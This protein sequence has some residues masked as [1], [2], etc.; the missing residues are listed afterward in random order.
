MSKIKL[1]ILLATIGT[2]SVRSTAIAQTKPAAKPATDAYRNAQWKPEK[3]K[4]YFSHA[5]IYEYT[6]KRDE[7]KG[8]IWI[9]IDPVTGTMCFQRESSFG[10]T[11]DMNELILALPNGKMIA[12]GTTESGKKIQ[13][14]FQNSSVKPEPDE[15]KDQQQTFREQ[16]KPTGNKRPEFGWESQE[17]VLSYLK[18]NESTKLWVAEVPFKVYPL[19]AFDEWEGDAQLPVSFS[20]IYLLGPNQLVTESDDQYGSLKLLSYEPNPLF[21]DLNQYAKQY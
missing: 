8:E 19:Y 4:Y 15:V 7:T 2:W 20:Y 14:A 16:C 9:F 10:A 21:L 12:C 1:L 18:T 5:L 3:G 11:D 6:R 13:A 17:Y